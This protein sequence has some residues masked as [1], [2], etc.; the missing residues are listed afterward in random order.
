M[1]NINDSGLTPGA[2]PSAGDGQIIKM[3]MLVIILQKLQYLAVKLQKKPT[4]SDETRNIMI[5]I[6]THCQSIDQKIKNM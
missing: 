2:S 4:I 1:K 5:K 6:L 3:E